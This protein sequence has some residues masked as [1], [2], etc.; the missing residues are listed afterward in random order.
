[1]IIRKGNN[2]VKMLRINLGFFEKSEEPTAKRKSDARKQGQVALS[3]ELGN[4]VAFITTFWTL[5][6]F[7]GYYYE[8][9]AKFYVYDFELIKDIDKIFENKYINEFIIYSFFK[10]LFICLPV[11]IMAL[12]A[13]I[14][15]NIMQVGWKPTTKPLMPKLSKFNPINGFKRMFSMQAVMELL[16]SLLK[17]VFITIA[18]WSSLKDKLFDIQKLIVMDLI[19]GVKYICDLCLDL[20][21]MIGYCFIV[22]AVVDFAYTRYSH[23]KKLKM[24]KQEVKDE[25]KQQE[26]DPTIKGKIRQKMRQIS[27]RRM[28]QEVPNADVVITNPTHF[29]VALKYDRN[30]ASAPIVVAKGADHLAKKIKAVAGEN[31]IEIVENKP[32]A[33]T[34]YKTVEVG[35]EIPPELYAAVAEVLSYVYKLKN[36]TSEI[37]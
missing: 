10:V 11:F 14:I 33:R 17:V 8:E 15:I 22:I 30:V 35:N 1:M 37:L 23:R 16:K 5:K 3:T 4:A 6:I 31:K 24:S 18:I 29:A 28:M 25:Y 9:C 26:G 21:I 32:L 12:V 34:L 7:S 36:R 13:G 19:E 2:E 27:M 20:G